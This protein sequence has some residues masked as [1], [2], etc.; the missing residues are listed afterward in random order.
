MKNVCLGAAVV[1][2][3]CTPA[4][5]ASRLVSVGYTTPSALHG[6]RVVQRID[7]LHTAEV[8]VPNLRGERQ[9]RARPGIRFVQRTQAR[10]DTGGPAFPTAAAAAVPEW[11][12]PALHAD[13]VPAWV[14]AAAS[15]ITIAVIDTGADTTVPSLAAKNPI[16]YNIV[17]G[18]STVHDDVGH[19]TFVA[20]LAGGSISDPNG[21]SGFGGDAQLMIIQANRGG[22]GFS[23]IDEANAIVWAV[24]NHANVINL[25]LGGSQTSLVER[26]AIQY[27][28][29]HGVLL[30]AAAGNSAEQ[31]NPTVYPAALLGESGLAVGAATAAGTRAPFSTTGTYVDVLAPGV[32][33][34]G[35]LASGVSSGFFS[36]IATPGATGN[37]ALGSGT[38]YSAPEVSGAAALVW[39][40]NPS[41]DAAGVAA[42]IE[43]TASGE[44]RWTQ[45]LAFGELNIA[46][47]VQRATGG[48]AP[49]LDKPAVLAK[50][51]TMSKPKAHAATTTHRVK[52]PRA[53][54]KAAPRHAH[55]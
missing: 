12:W 26:S 1:A 36:P 52:A 28:T 6:L 17:T 48:P 25:S 46:A 14:S 40:A 53:K 15:R 18:T 24:D 55:P 21:M 51:V 19:G 10:R 37:Y 29:D 38:S 20:S 7:A 43:A 2:L 31:G 9:L 5:A 3:M 54:I 39:A 30:V 41:L 23:D 8:R 45:D 34:L 35:A 33:V 50:P 4:A 22:T 27:A 32:D 16:T 13:L 49:Q 47:A 11:Q 44:G 42:I